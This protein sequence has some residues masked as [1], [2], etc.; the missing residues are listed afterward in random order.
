VVNALRFGPIHVNRRLTTRIQRLMARGAGAGG[1]SES[2]T[3]ES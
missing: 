3:T 1:A 2:V